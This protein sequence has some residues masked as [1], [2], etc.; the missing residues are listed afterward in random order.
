MIIK[1]EKCQTKFRLDDSRVTAKGVKVRCTKC[2]HVFTV[3]KEEAPAESFELES[4]YA[5]FSAPVDPKQEPVATVEREQSVAEAVPDA[6][7]APEPFEHVS[8]GSEPVAK[9]G[10][11]DFSDFDFN[12]GDAESDVTSR[13]DMPVNDF[14]AST[15]PPV[16]DE[17]QKDVPNKLEP[18]ADD[19]FGDI[20]LP[21]FKATGEA[22]SFD[23]EEESITP[24]L[25]QSESKPSDQ[26][27]TS[28]RSSLFSIDT[29]VD[30]PFNLGDI[31]FGDE[32][33]KAAVPEMHAEVPKPATK[34]VF[35]PT[36][37]IRSTVPAYEAMPSFPEGNSVDE[38][39]L[40][41]LLIAS[42]RKQ[43]PLFG[44]VLSIVAVLLIAILGYFGY[45]SF[46]TPKEVIV[47]ESGKIS[48]RA[49]K[50][51]Y[52]DNKT[53]GELL[54]ISGEA[55]NQYPKPR[56]ALQVKVTVFDAAGQHAATKN[57]YGGN[58]L[59]EEQLKS[60]PL[61]KIEAAMGNQFGDSL[62]NM[63]VAP[64]KAIPF[65]VVLAN[66]PAG[67]KDFTVEPVGSTVATGK[68]P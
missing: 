34:I 17:P 40:P 62:A 39:E 12:A 59:T 53:A 48:V 15:I 25:P 26:N 54:V 37:E 19:M 64:G 30:A 32:P 42:R 28:E 4:A 14:T 23:F 41:P 57:A 51:V 21:E 50:A 33:A 24:P 46:S 36:D 44:A 13:F 43:S 52:I 58:P 3:Q 22:I 31:D 63:E 60:L 61:D 27:S 16:A 6:A 47:P 68:Q 2:K 29:A 35:P 18:H 45:V 1:C 55:L 65:V 5:G 11:I 56:A 8:G 7:S 9:R 66:L 38:Q 67:S 20:V 49:V 10:E